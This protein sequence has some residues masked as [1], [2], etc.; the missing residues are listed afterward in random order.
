MYHLCWS[1]VFNPLL[2]AVCVFVWS[3]AI[4]KYQLAKI[5][6]MKHWIARI[7]FRAWKKICEYKWYFYKYPVLLS[8]WAYMLYFTSSLVECTR[9]ECLFRQLSPVRPCRPPPMVWSLPQPVPAHCPSPTQTAQCPV[10]VA[11]P[12]MEQAPSLVTPT[13]SGT[14]GSIHHVS[15]YDLSISCLTE[16]RNTQHIQV[17]VWYTLMNNNCTCMTDLYCI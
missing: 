9:N 13:D 14:Q 11:T 3:R 5:V 6:K 12:C 10:R 7:I 4:K 16:I 17:C 1:R 8:G 2:F 15:R